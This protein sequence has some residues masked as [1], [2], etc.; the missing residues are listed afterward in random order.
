MTDKA[1][2]NLGIFMGT[3]HAWGQGETWG[4]MSGSGRPHGVDESWVCARCGAT[5]GRGPGSNHCGT[6]VIRW[7]YRTADGRMVDSLGGCEG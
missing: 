3:R 6:R 5:K 1:R 2:R 4:V 7:W